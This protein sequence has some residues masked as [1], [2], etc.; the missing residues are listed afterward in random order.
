M[1]TRDYFTISTVGNDERT[2]DDIQIKRRR[3]K[4]AKV[5]DK[6][7]FVDEQVLCLRPEDVGRVG[8]RIDALVHS[9]GGSIDVHGCFIRLNMGE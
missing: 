1:M 3:F 2:V 9:A 5:G 6:E 8:P 7:I 4:F